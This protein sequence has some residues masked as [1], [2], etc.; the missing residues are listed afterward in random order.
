MKI[1]TWILGLLAL[2]VGGIARAD[3]KTKAVQET[4]EA[5]M[6]RFGV[7][8]GRSLPALIEKI[9][10]L[11]ARYGEE[12]LV[13]VRRVGPEAFT[14]VEEAGVNGSRAVRVLAEFG[15]EG[16][17]CVLRRPAA[18]KQFLRYGEGAASVLVR[19]PGVA[20]GL[21]EKGGAGAVRALAKVTPQ[22]A[23][24]MAMVL[25]GELKAVAPKA[26]LLEVVGK[27]GQ[28]AC[29]F[30][31]ANKG[32]LAGAAAMT[33]FLANPEPYLNGVRNLAE[34]TVVPVAKPVVNGI[35]TALHVFLGVLAMLIVACG[36]LLYKH[37]HAGSII[38][39]LLHA[40]LGK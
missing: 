20:E 22:G 32:V 14:L 38:A 18:M 33:A 13:A 6:A 3:V 19:H 2:S 17:T 21:I 37:P 26:E 7:R 40:R 4:A 16:A 10:S 36:I 34:V 39:H 11:A 28:R 27:Y 23:R 30:I 31:W 8:A 5:V 24:R 12:A 25:E 35:F 9:E 29:D 15:E 1:R